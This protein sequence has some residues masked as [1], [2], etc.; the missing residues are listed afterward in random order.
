M[1]TKANIAAAQKHPSG[2]RGKP[3]S[4]YYT[5]PHNHFALGKTGYIPMQRWVS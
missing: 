4:K 1:S 5:K 3:L 2:E